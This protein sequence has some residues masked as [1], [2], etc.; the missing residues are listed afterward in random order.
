[1]TPKSKALQI[2]N[3]SSRS[4]AIITGN[5]LDHMKKAAKI[6]AREGYQPVGTRTFQKLLQIANEQD[7]LRLVLMTGRVEGAESEVFI[8]HLRNSQSSNHNT[9][10]ILHD[11]E[12]GHNKLL[13]EQIEAIYIHCMETEPLTALT[14]K[15]RSVTSPTP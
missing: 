1:M 3:K 5:N 8:R 4:H 6:C 14:E 10:I 9:P 12:F 2:P 13:A 15:I 7:R 11:D